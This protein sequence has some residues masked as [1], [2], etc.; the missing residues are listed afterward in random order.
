MATSTDGLANDLRLKLELV[1]EDETQAGAL[2]RTL[3]DLTAFASYAIPLIDL[4]DSLPETA[5]WG[6]WLDQFGLTRHSG[7]QIP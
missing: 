5:S 3:E 6:E 1:E 2:A 4:L 7:A